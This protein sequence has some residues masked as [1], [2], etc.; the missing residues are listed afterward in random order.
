[1]QPQP[2]EHPFGELLDGTLSPITQSYQFEKFGP[3]AADVVPGHPTQ[4]AV[5]FQRR[6][7]SMMP[8]NSMAFGKVPDAAAPA[9]IPGRLPQEGRRA[10]RL[11]H[12][13][14]QHFDEGR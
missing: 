2:L 8:R 13:P 10:A 6:I 9:P 4:A 14:E 11:S 3:A 7:R 1:R 12:D 5:I